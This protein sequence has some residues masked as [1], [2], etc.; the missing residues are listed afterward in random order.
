MST[1]K[2][3]PIRP[4]ADINF[5]VGQ[6]SQNL[7]FQGYNVIPTVMSPTTASIVV[8]KDRDGFKNFLGLGVECRVSMTINNGSLMLNIDHEWT[9]KIIAIVIGW[10][11]C[12]IPFITGIVGAVNQ[13][14]LPAKIETAVMQACNS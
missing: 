5:I 8:Q 6:V 11:L 3:L 1:T 13:N 7:Q 10:F 12:L 14:S 2:M 9:N 4:D